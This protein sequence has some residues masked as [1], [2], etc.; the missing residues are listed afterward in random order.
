MDSK[1]IWLCPQGFES[2][3]CRFAVKQEGSCNASSGH[4]Q[5]GLSVSCSFLSSSSDR[6]GPPVLPPHR[7]S[8]RSHPSLPLALSCVP[9][10]L[11]LLTCPRLSLPPPSPPSLPPYLSDSLSLPLFSVALP[12]SPPSAGWPA[13]LS[14]PLISMRYTTGSRGH[15]RIEPGTC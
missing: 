10:A 3:R 4:Q 12:L 13:G 8:F 15:T 5:L 7:F 9:R 11:P 6:L 1:S 14:G 2:P